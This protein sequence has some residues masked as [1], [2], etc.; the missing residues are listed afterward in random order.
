MPLTPLEIHNKEFPRK[1]MGGYDPDAVDEFLDEVVGEFENLTREV[2]RL[3]D[4]V[5]SLTERL[6]KY[7]HMEDSINKAI[8]AA[9]DAAEK[10]ELNAKKQ[11][12]NILEE[13]KLQAERVLESGQAKSRKIMEE[14]SDLARVVSTLRTQVRTLLE[15]QLKSLAELNDPF[16]QAASSRFTEKKEF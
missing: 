12:E 4:S 15:A 1:M 5:E 3:K 14:N 2:N 7:R 11:A 13:A 8:T 6:E 16:G 10:M 9:Q